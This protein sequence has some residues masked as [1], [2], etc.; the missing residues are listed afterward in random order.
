[1]SAWQ[2]HHAEIEHQRPPQA[3]QKA[4]ATNG[5]LPIRQVLCSLG[6]DDSPLSTRRFCG[7]VM[8]RTTFVSCIVAVVTCAGCG[9]ARHAESLIT[10]E[11]R[12]SL[13]DYLLWSDASATR[14]GIQCVE[15]RMHDG[16]M[17]DGWVLPSSTRPAKGTMVLLHGINE[18]KASWPYHGIAERL[19]RK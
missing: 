8:T 12:F 9:P 19:A 16:T 2:A 5:I 10:P 15:L 4:L 6:T 14:Q 11:S 7:G 1:M 18:S 17:I 3:V 13:P